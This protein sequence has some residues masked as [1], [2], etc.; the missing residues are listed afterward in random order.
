MALEALVPRVLPDGSPRAL[1]EPC[2]WVLLWLCCRCYIKRCCHHV[3]WVSHHQTQAS[4]SYKTPA[5]LWVAG[6]QIE[7]LRALQLGMDFKGRVMN[8][9]SAM[10]MRGGQSP[11]GTE[12]CSSG[13][14]S[15]ADTP[16]LLFPLVESGKGNTTN[17]QTD[18]YLV[19]NDL[20]FN[21]F[22]LIFIKY[23]L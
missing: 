19:Q 9:M 10:G 23:T 4:G 11:V 13:S 15:S 2:S 16:S 18:I 22:S 5:F 17:G 21:L 6:G 8:P 14:F 3:G 20:N 7:V 1:L 12:C